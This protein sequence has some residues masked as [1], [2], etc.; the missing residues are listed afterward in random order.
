MTEK[1]ASELAAERLGY[2][3][4]PRTEVL[5][6]LEDLLS[7]DEWSDDD[8]EAARATIDRAK[9]LPAPDVKDDAPPAET[10]RRKTA[11]ELAADRLNGQRES[12]R[13]SSRGWR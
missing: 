9:M 5:G 2:G 12:A 1:T 4:D 11:S 7:R 8:R 13:R 6:D 3:I 10:G